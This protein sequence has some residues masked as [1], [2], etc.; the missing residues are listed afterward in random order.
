MPRN[1]YRKSIEQTSS[2][3]KWKKQRIN[4]KPKIKSEKEYFRAY[5]IDKSLKASSNNPDY[6]KKEPNRNDLRTIDYPPARM[7]KK[8]RYYTKMKVRK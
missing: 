4:K 6:W 3:K 2:F 7:P 5:Q 8:K 1:K